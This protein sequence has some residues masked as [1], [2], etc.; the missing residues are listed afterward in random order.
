MAKIF[1]QKIKEMGYVDLMA[2][3]GEVNRPPGGKNAV[4]ILVQN[5]FIT[6]DSKVLD[7]GCNTGY[8]SFEITHLS[9][10]SVVGI[11]ISGNMIRAAEKIRRKDS[12]GHLIKFKV[13][14]AMNLPFR[15]ETFDVV[16]SGGS[17]A[18]IKDKVRAIQEY[19][20]VLKQWGFIADINFFYRIKPPTSLLRRLNS[21]L[22]IEIQPWDMN[23]WLSLYEQC[24]LE[25]YFIHTDHIKPVSRAEIE[26]YCSVM[27][28]EKNLSKDIEFE[29]RK[30]LVKIMD[31]FNENHKYLDYGIFILRKRPEKEQISLFGA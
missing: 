15:K 23:Y 25:R 13:A 5:C 2:F 29:L 21:I 30:K 22:E 24:D 4:R 3:L 17:T 31:V 10:C 1:S 7:V 20:R 16:V 8:I 6:K 28:S 19:K 18:F 14:D 27:A 9:K 11:D 12:L 26:N